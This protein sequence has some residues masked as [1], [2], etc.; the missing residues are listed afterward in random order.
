VEPFQTVEA[1]NNLKFTI[2][3]TALVAGATS[4]NGTAR[5]GNNVEF[6]ALA[7]TGSTFTASNILGP[8]GSV[9]GP[10]EIDYGCGK[11]IQENEL[12]LPRV[13]VIPESALHHAESGK[14]GESY[15]SRQLISVSSAKPD[16]SSSCPS[17]GY[18]S[19]RNAKAEANSE[20]NEDEIYITNGATLTLNAGSDYVFCSLVTNGPIALN[21]ASSSSLPVRIFID[22]PSSAR[23]NHFVE[24]NSIKAGSFSATQG[25]GG[26]GTTMSP[27][28]MQIYLMGNGTNG[29]TSFTSSGGSSLASG[30]FLYAPQS[31]VNLETTSFSQDVGLNNYPLSSAAGVFH[32]T[33]YTQCPLNN[34]AGNAV[35]QLGM[36]SAAEDASGC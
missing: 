5:V 2:P 23:C 20:T 7:K 25:V 12:K 28:Q 11:K 27:T 10:A 33:G 19:G 6:S 31:E 21:G 17:T 35:T 8:G 1:I 16:C 30:F 26:A 3:G 29:G 24:H 34:S 22:S 13:T 15:F 32:V 4:F 36:V 9:I 14:C 18:V